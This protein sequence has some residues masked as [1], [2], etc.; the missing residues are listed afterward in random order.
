MLIVAS[1][2]LGLFCLLGAFD[3]LYFHLYKYRL[4]EVPSAK[5]E[6]QLHTARAFV[7]VPLA[8]TLFVFNS[9]G[10][11]LYL[12][13]FFVILDAVLELVDILIER[14]ARAPI[15][16][17]SSEE[18]AVHV[19][20]SG[21]KFAAIVL[22]LV[23]KDASAYSLASP[24]LL[25]VQSQLLSVTGALFALGCL[26]GGVASVALVAVPKLKTKVLSLCPTGC[27]VTK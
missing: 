15:G 25:A 4:H 20:A 23:S 27:P 7:F 26:G 22:V 5:L 2:F 12:G 6:H 8:I 11:A 16:G 21:F 17:I 13:I 9:A 18:T 19:F 3:G 24:S 14:D 10:A 1:I